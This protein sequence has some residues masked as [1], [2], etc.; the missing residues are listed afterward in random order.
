MRDKNEQCPGMAL[1]QFSAKG[2]GTDD[3]AQRTRTAKDDDFFAVAHSLKDQPQPESDGVPKAVL[4][5][6]EFFPR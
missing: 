4:E 5:G 6:P 2:Q 1:S 3:V